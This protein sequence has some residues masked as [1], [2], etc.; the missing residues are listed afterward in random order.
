MAVA[1]G[2]FKVAVE[3]ALLPDA[4]DDDIWCAMTL[5]SGLRGNVT[6]ALVE[7]PKLLYQGFA[8]TLKCLQNMS[9]G[10]YAF[11]DYISPSQDAYHVGSPT[12]I[13]VQPPCY[14]RAPDFAFDL[15]PLTRKPGSLF[16]LADLSSSKL[17]M[18]LRRRNSPPGLETKQ[19][20][21]QTHN[22]ADSGDIAVAED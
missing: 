1:V 12:R 5:A 14:S 13:V 2:A 22:K 8:H 18:N 17:Q 19:E 16:T 11:S 7:Y 20:A 9:D 21:Q 3:L 10:D 15:Q 4:S 6:M